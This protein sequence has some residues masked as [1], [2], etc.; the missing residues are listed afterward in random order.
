MFVVGDGTQYFHP[1]SAVKNANIIEG[2]GSEETFLNSKQMF[3]YNHPS[4]ERSNTI[5]IPK[6]KTEMMN[7]R[8]SV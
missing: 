8:R 1:L 5:F 7:E 6:S 3:L 4:G 2:F